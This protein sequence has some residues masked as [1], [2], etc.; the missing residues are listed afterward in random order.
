VRLATL[1]VCERE[2]VCALDPAR[3]WLPLDS[4]AGVP[5]GADALGLIRA[6]L[7][8]ALRARIEQDLAT[9]PDD[10]FV[11]PADA[12]LAA[13]GRHP[14]LV[15]GI[16]LNYHAH[17]EDLGAAVPDEPASFVKL[18]H[19]IIGP[20]EPIV[21]PAQSER[22]TAEA[23]LGLVIGRRA[24]Q[25]DPAD[26]LA[27]VAAVCCVLDQT[28]E[29]ILQRDPRFLTRAKNFPT[30]LAL[31]PELV[32]LDEVLG[33]DGTLD[34][35]MVGTWRDGELHREAP[36]ARMRSGPA[37]LVAFHSR[38]FPLEPG[39]VILT[40][41][42]GAVVVTAGAEAECRIPG[43]GSLRARVVRA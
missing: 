6:G 2:V 41:T 9:A 1:V 32:T 34:H 38:V 36:V 11:A 10:H 39:D 33:A 12:V 15:W 17:A 23:E 30:F 5:P 31:G 37:E 43:V 24:W 3:G 16:G 35:L 13:P 42:P 8:P 29:D 4:V 19:T 28:A 26:A 22:V 40:G 25:V 14:R 7:D 27:H 18:P 21:L 20:G